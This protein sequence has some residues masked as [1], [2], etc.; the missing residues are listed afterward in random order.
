MREVKRED[1]GQVSGGEGQVMG[2]KKGRH[3]GGEERGQGAG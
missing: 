3:E 2:E 1:K